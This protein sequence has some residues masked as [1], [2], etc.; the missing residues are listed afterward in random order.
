MNY[1]DKTDKEK[2]SIFLDW[3]NNYLTYE[4]FSSDYGISIEQAE[5]L[6]EECRTIHERLVKKSLQQKHQKNL[7]QV[8]SF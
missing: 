8:K 4:K 5:K 7:E 1:N 2:Q 3:F 6:I